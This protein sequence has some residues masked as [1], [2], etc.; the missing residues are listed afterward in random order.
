MDFTNLSFFRSARATLFF[1]NAADNKSY[2]K[3]VFID[4]FARERVVY[5]NVIFTRRVLGVCAEF[6]SGRMHAL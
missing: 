2:L 1:Y 3:D 5:G 4:M 6:R